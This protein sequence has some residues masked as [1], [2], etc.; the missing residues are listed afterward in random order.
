MKS[1]VF[2]PVLMCFL[3]LL[4]Q[5]IVYAANFGG[6]PVIVSQRN[7]SDW[8]VYAAVINS[9]GSPYASNPTITIDGVST[10][11]PLDIDGDYSGFISM[12][13]SDLNT[14]KTV[15]WNFQNNSFTGAIPQNSLLDIPLSENVGFDKFGSHPVIHW[16]TPSFAGF[17]Y[18]RIAVRNSAGNYVSINNLYGMGI[19]TQQTYDFINAKDM[20][21]NPFSFLPDESYKILVQPRTAYIYSNLTI[22]GTSD[23]GPQQIILNRSQYVQPYSYSAPVPIPSSILLLGF[24][25][26]GIAGAGRKKR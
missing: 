25:I 8:K 11:L 1:K 5:G 23:Q 3:L 2:I 13:P 21:G 24:G 10:S 15:E 7:Q 22:T 18:Y 19:G 16:T 14:G 17:S 20:S 26:L 9:S 4:G 12:N 6:T